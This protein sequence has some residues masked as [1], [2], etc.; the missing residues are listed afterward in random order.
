MA[1]NVQE[2]ESMSTAVE[3][4]DREP[5][6]MRED[7]GDGITILTL[8]RPGKYNALSE[9]MLTAMQQR[10]GELEHDESV[11]VVVL[12]ANGKA[13]SAGHDLKEMRSKH[14]EEYYKALFKQCG[15]VMLGLLSLPQPVIARVQGMATAAG[16]QLVANCDLAVAGT[17][18]KFA[19]SGVN[20][21]L[22][23]S[24]PGVALSRN[25]PRKRAFEMLFTGDFID[26]R[27]A[28][29]WGLINRVVPPDTLDDEAMALAGNIAAKAPVAVRIGKRLFY[30]QIVKA[31]PEAYDYA[32]AVMA[33]NMLEEDTVE[34]V[35]AFLEK[36]KPS[37]R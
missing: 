2:S 32:G 21:G 5:L 10:I 4:L 23:C 17:E 14:D 37:Y 1:A 26:A 19:V 3:K 7:R 27:T 30:E 36:R 12:A 22:F 24:T 28:S 15:A 20:L 18:A 35:D 25:V 33:G 8:N 6:V 16:C 29:E 11:R 34:G 13:F 9:D 31:L